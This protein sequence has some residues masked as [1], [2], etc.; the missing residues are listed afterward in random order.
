MAREATYSLRIDTAQARRE[1]RQFTRDVQQEMN[2][3]L[4]QGAGRTGGARG[5]V[6]RGTS[7]LG[8]LAV[9]AL[10]G[11]AGAFTVREI[12]QQAVQISRLRS[13][14]LQ[15]EAAFQQLSGSEQDAAQNLAAVM[16]A[17]QGTVTELEAQ[18]LATTASS[19]LR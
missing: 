4:S 17:T 8:G 9:G 7:A 19:F 18:K 1:V 3:G 11:L 10:G 12:A 15:A 5:A 6:G 16:R 13:E 2:R 14:V